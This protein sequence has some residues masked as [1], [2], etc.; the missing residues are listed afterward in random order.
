MLLSIFMPKYLQ[1]QT[2][3]AL[4]SSKPGTLMSSIVIIA[5]AA[6]CRKVNSPL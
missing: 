5:V 4:I 2:Q 1:Y 3:F 6:N